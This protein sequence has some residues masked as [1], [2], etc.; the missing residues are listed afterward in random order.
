MLY[1]KKSILIYPEL[2][3]SYRQRFISEIAKEFINQRNKGD[4]PLL[5]NMDEIYNKLSLINDMFVHR[6]C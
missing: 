3:I 6:R 1:R 4:I 2:V 5:K